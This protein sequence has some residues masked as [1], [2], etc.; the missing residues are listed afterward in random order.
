[1]DEPAFATRG[2]RRNTP[3]NVLNRI[4]VPARER[5]N[6]LLAAQG[7]PPIPH[8]TPHTL[9]HTFASLLAVCNVPPRRAMYLLG[10][11]DAKLTP[12]V[13]QQVLDKAHGS[14]ELL[15][16]ALGATLDEARDTL[17]GQAVGGP[18]WV[19]NG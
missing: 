9:R 17:C 6:E 10:H 18:V 11:T 4:V 16:T 2:G 7:R 5:A 8:L 12:S 19:V 14:I 1:V 15:E 3:N 13:H